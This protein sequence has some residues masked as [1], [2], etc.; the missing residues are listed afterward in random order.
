[1]HGLALKSLAADRGKLITA[2]IGVVFSLVLVNVQGG[3]YFGL[4]AKSSLLVDRFDA[5][6]WVGRRGVEN[7]DLGYEIPTAWLS[8]IRGLRGVADAAP[9]IIGYGMASAPNGDYEGVWVVGVEPHRLSDLDWPMV[10][11]RADDLHRPHAI[12]IDRLDAWKLGQPALGDV[13]EINGHRARVTAK[14]HG[15][16]GFMTTPYVL[17]TIDHARDF[18]R[19]PSDRCTYFLVEAAEGV[20]AETLRDRIQQ[21]VPDADVYTRDDFR[22][23]S[24]Q[25]WMKRTGIGVSFGAATLLGILV[26]FLMVGQSL[27][28]M[29]LDHL[30]EYATLKALGAD[31][32]Q[33]GSVV[34][35]QAL[36]IAAIGAV[37]GT[38]LVV[39]IQRALSSPLAPIDIPLALLAGAVGLVFCVCLVATILPWQRIR[40]VDPI[41]VL[42]R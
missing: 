38:V 42:Q 39:V 37:V 30:D 10:E 15:V 33:V 23:L 12:C 19:T 7:V 2:L 28:G 16:L 17:T 20:S 31:E 34:I 6:V 36:A 5:D 3:L 29:A 13:L 41:T 27:Y 40:R 11:G 22:R 4:I 26:G 25:Y 9:C 8:R 14:T 32:W 21:A 18:T 24:Q 35:S 1:M